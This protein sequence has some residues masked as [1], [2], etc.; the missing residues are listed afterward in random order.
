[1]SLSLSWLLLLNSFAFTK[2]GTEEISVQST[3]VFPLGNFNEESAVFE[4]VHFSEVFIR[5]KA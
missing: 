4:N 2:W 3:L 1:V 5:D